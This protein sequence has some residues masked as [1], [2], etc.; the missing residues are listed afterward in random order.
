[1][2]AP[3]SHP[4]SN[5]LS[6]PNQGRIVIADDDA[7][8]RDTLAS[9]LRQTGYEC[10]CAPDSASAIQL[11]GASHFDLLISDLE[12]PGNEN[13]DLIHQMSRL[14]PGLPVILLTAHPTIESAAQSVRLPVIAYLVKPPNLEELQKVVRQSIER[15]HAY[16]TVNANRQRLQDW[17]RDLTLIEGHLT[18][19]DDQPAT[20][21]VNDYL[22]LTFQ[23]LIMSMADLKQMLQAV[24]RQEGKEEALSQIS[25]LEALRKTV[26]VLANT[27]QSFKSRE[28]GDLRHKLEELLREQEGTKP[29]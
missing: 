9:F 14:S 17:M 18:R 5:P 27:K 13:L 22:T 11:L 21:H 26:E 8:F 19:G 29:G 25:L 28:L 23:N 16:R 15:Y 2:P 24:A 12:M 4:L 20:G 3:S 1:M 10:V 6:G 7:L